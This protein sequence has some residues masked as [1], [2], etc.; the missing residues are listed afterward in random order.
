MNVGVSTEVEPE[1]AYRALCRFVRPGNSAL[2]LTDN[3]AT[4]A[5]I[6]KGYS[7]SFAVNRAANRIRSG[8]A[9]SKIVAQ[10]IAGVNNP[11]DG[12]SRG[13]EVCLEEVGEAI[14]QHVGVT[15]AA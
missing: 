2:I 15:S 1:A 10:H 14:R 7:A 5:A 4:C 8:F 6:N 3:M 12:S 11:A 9:S 13:V